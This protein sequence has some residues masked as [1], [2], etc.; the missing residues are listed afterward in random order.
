M[1]ELDMCVKFVTTLILLAA[2][3]TIFVASSVNCITF[4][5]PE[6][7]ITLF[8]NNMPVN[9]TAT[10][11]EG[12]DAVITTNGTSL[13][14][15]MDWGNS[16][17]KTVHT[18]IIF[19]TQIFENRTLVTYYPNGTVTVDGANG[20]WM[21]GPGIPPVANSTSV[22]DLKEKAGNIWSSANVYT[23]ELYDT[24]NFGN[25]TVV[26]QYP[27]G[28][29]SANS[30]IPSGSGGKATARSIIASGIMALVCFFVVL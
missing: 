12:P 25:G 23:N 16:T 3:I 9:T 22:L 28:T 27:N 11:P 1:A 19:V 26:T 7:T 15:T 10:I 20:P 29:Q 21:D 4:K 14:Y 30:P 18:D 8:M 5:V 17:T 13:I 24:Y 2:F 6:G